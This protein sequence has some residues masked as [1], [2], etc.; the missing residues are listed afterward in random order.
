MKP[1]MTPRD[2]VS[3]ALGYSFRRPELL[4]QALTH[5]STAQSRAGRLGTNERLE[6]LGDRAL[7]LIVAEWLYTRFPEEDEGALA[8][9]FASLV[10]REALAE[11]AERMN[12]GDHLVLNAEDTTAARENPGVLA[13]ACEAL[14]GALY[15]DG[16]LD[17]VRPFIE[18]YWAGILEADVEPPRDAKTALQEWAQGRGLPL[19][20]YREIGR[21]GPPHEPVFTMEARV[22]GH[23][24]IRA[25]GASKRLA[26]QA[27][28]RDLLDRIAA[29]D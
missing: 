7:G 2:Q 17:A 21:D 13:D 15:L 29:H 12:I 1:I 14:I 24:P 26:E 25:Q 23:E 4:D 6:F 9:R 5:S 20:V 27:A 3:E 16:G 22:E 11:V 8:R 28:A 18:K 10:R 19:P